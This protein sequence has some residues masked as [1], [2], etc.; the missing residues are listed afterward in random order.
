MKINTNTV[1]LVLSI[2]IYVLKLISKSIPK[3]Q[4]YCAAAKKFG[5]SER[6]VRKHMKKY[7]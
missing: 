1:K 4:A 6:F 2:L 7:I 3:E 5:V